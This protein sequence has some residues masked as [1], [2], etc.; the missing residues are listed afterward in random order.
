[1]NGGNFSYDFRMLLIHLVPKPFASIVTALTLVVPALTPLILFHKETRVRASLLPETLVLFG[2]SL[3][4]ESLFISPFYFYVSLSP[5]LLFQSST[6]CFFRRR[7]NLNRDFS[8][9]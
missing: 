6:K 9:T 2:H 1:M 4:T 3:C 5:K 7:S 8:I